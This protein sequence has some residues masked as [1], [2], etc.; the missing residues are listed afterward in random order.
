M[1]S[2]KNRKTSLPSRRMV[3]V[4]G[5]LLMTLIGLS[6]CT[7]STPHRPAPVVDPTAQHP[8]KSVSPAPVISAVTSPTGQL[9]TTPLMP[10]PEPTLPPTEAP[11]A[12]PV[13]DTAPLTPE[14]NAPTEP[15]GQMVK[16]EAVISLK[17]LVVLLPDR[18]S[19]QQ[20]NRDI[21]QGIRQSHKQAPINANTEII[22]ISDDLP[23]DQLVAKVNGFA[24]D[25]IIGP[26][27]KPDIQGVG[28]QLSA[29]IQIALNRYPEIDHRLQV[30]LAPEDELTQLLS[31]RRYKNMPIAVFATQDAQ[32][33]RLLAGLEQITAQDQTPILQIPTSPAGTDV[34]KW[35]KEEGN[36]DNSQKRIVALK[37]ALKQ[38]V[39]AEPRLRTDIQAFISLSS[40]KNTRPLI[41]A[42]RFYQA[43]WK[44]LA[45]SKALPT[46]KG[47]VLNEPD[48]TGMEV[49]VP[50]YLLNDGAIK[51]AFEALG[52]DAYQL[53][54]YRDVSQFAGQTGKLTSQNHQVHRQLEWRNFRKGTLVNWQP[55]PNAVAPSPSNETVAA[56]T[57]E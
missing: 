43:N 25:A 6:A 21:V 4:S 44:L 39:Q 1:T 56:P 23:V 50:P 57:A 22:V 48:L 46:V 41:P 53:L 36:L 30:S 31:Q 10:T 18:P 35:L 5:S 9:Q 38:S 11:I 28:A 16:N 17:R 42:L 34:I 13:S 3:R 47:S 55:N 15:A 26:L 52:F 40:A 19:L 20:V 12:P 14:I 37:Q 27:T 33:K 45:T 8:S 24:P 7:N 51:N 32:D 54:A 29:P 49:L 2:D